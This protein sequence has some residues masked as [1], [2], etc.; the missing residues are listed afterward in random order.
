MPKYD[1]HPITGCRVGSFI[2]DEVVWLIDPLILEAIVAE[3]KF[4]ASQPGFFQ[5]ADDPAK[6]P[7]PPP[8]LYHLDNQGV[9]RI[10]VDGP[11]TKYESS[12]GNPSTLGIQ[13]A[14]RAGLQ[15]D[16][17]KAFM[18]NM[19]S[20]GGTHTG[21]PELA[22]YIRQVDAQKPVYAHGDGSMT[23]AAYYLASAARRVTASRSTGVGSIGTFA[24]L[25]DLSKAYE[26]D[27]IKVIPIAS[28]EFKAMGAP[29]VPVTD[30]HIAEARRRMEVINDNFVRDV[31]RHRRD[32]GVAG[33]SEQNVRDLK[34]RVY[35]G[36]E[37]V[38]KGLV[39]QICTIDQALA[40][41]SSHSPI[42]GTLARGP[43][44]SVST[45]AASQRSHAMPMTMAEQMKLIRDHFEAAVQLS[46]GDL[47]EFAANMLVAQKKTISDNAAEITRLKNELADAKMQVVPK[48]NDE[49][50]GERREFL[51]GNITQLER[52]G[53][54]TVAQRDQLTAIISANTPLA[55][56]M[57]QRGPDGK[58]YMATSILDIFR[59]NTKQII[60]KQQGGDPQPQDRPTPGA[61]GD[62]D[63]D[64]SPMQKAAD[65]VVDSVYKRYHSGAVAMGQKGVVNAN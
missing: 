33:L 2:S 63:G 61:T 10:D 46:D 11:I 18:L 24:M 56:L 14:F 30:E 12:F 58:G 52:D 39:D 37:A 13:K 62:G 38:G 42:S 29:G 3:A 27:G 22:D 9:A 15:D 41:A 28:S 17:V 44:V 16:K 8:P 21:I 25:R 54:I 47:S 32:N 26:M 64:K 51:A 53:L 45:A 6:P 20:P 35:M 59:N 48:L 7:P 19:D 31:S 60:T 1:R 50:A 49:L 34:A 4:K 57:L 36:D 23:S 65:T 40:Y 43:I 5:L 55:N